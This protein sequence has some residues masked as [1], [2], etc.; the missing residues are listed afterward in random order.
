MKASKKKV[1]KFIGKLQKVSKKLNLDDGEV[2]ESLL[3]VYSSLSLLHGI[4]KK[5]ALEGV[6]IMLDAVYKQTP[7]D[8]FESAEVH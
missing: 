4:T 1:A 3:V 7:P 8:L 5:E 2:V 6:D